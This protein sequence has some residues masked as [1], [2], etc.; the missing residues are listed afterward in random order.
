MCDPL[1]ERHLAQPPIPQFSFDDRTVEE[2]QTEVCQHTLFDR[3]QAADLPHD[4]KVLQRQ[5]LH[6]QRMFQDRPGTGTRFTDEQRFPA[7]ILQ[8]AHFA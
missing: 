4:Q 6:R 1:S 8:R 7:Q 2:C 3:M 5:L